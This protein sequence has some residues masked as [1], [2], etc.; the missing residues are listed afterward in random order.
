MYLQEDLQLMENNKEALG[1]SSQ[2]PMAW[3]SRP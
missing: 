1:G 3:L 2:A